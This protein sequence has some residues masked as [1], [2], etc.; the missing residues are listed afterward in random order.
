MR[1]EVHLE[2]RDQPRG[3]VVLRRAHRDARWDRRHRLVT[4]V[5]VD[6]VRGFPQLLG[7]NTGR[8]LESLEGFRERFTGDPVERQ[9]EWVHRCCD[10]V[11]SSL[12]CRER[13][14]DAHSGAPWT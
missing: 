10:E 6:D 7:L 5:L 9:R 4:D 11:G 2:R 13:G 14:G 12:D 3:E 1:A 8:V